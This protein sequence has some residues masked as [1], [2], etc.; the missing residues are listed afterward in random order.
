M[1]Q[2]TSESPEYGRWRLK[3]IAEER[4]VTMLDLV[5]EAI[6]AEGSIYKAAQKLGVSPTTVGYHLSRAGLGIRS[7]VKIEFYPLERRKR[8]T[9]KQIAR[10]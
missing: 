6:C 7:V 4:G 1:I 8:G 2:S 10:S 9:Q 3:E 5:K